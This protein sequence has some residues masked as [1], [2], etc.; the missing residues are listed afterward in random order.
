MNAPARTDGSPGV[1][2]DGTVRDGPRPPRGPLALVHPLGPLFR[3]LPLPLRR[4]LLYLR[5]KGRWG[6]FRAPRLHTEKLQWRIINDHRTVLALLCDKLASKSLVAAIATQRNPDLG[7]P[8]T[9]WVGTDVRELQRLAAHLPARW[10]LKPN[11]SSGRVRLLDSTRSPIDWSELI[12]AGDRW[13][14]PDEQ[15]EVLGHAAYGR[16]RRLLFAE[17]RIGSDDGPPVDLRAQVFEGTLRRMDYSMGLDTPA[18]RVCCYERDLVT[19]IFAGIAEEIPLD[20][21]TAIDAMGD[22]ARSAMRNTI[23]AIGSFVEYVR[24]DGY[25][26]EGRYWFG[27]FTAY[28]GGGL[29]PMGRELDPIAGALWQLPNLDIVD[30]REAEWRGHL[31]GT[32]HGTLQA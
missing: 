8:E 29:G 13:M 30:P 9:L 15:T 24:V 26:E 23:E 25:Y 28:A 1:R 18:H 14:L 20:E 5:H 32:P 3:R 4:H 21:R 16:A 11:H 10:V 27:E 31:A 12:A 2:S 22:A 17:Q 7:I 19:R 6:N